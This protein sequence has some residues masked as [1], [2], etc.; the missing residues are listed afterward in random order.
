METVAL[1]GAAGFVGRAMTSALLDAGYA[2]RACDLSPLDWTDTAAHGRK[3]VESGLPAPSKHLSLLYGDISDHGVVSR[4]MDGC[5]AAVHTTVFFPQAAPGNNSGTHSEEV[6]AKTWTTNL[7]GLWNVLDV[8]TAN[9]THRVVH[10]GSCTTVYPGSTHH[11]PGSL[12]MTQD[13]RRPDGSMYAVQKRLQEEMCECA[14]IFK[15][16]NYTC[17]SY[18]RY[19][20]A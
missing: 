6:L 18:A 9:G 8:A 5:I 19:T 20:R 7:K 13:V 3:R 1:F 11:P 4:A 16:V 15:H 2:V 17:S 10:I 12:V 14:F